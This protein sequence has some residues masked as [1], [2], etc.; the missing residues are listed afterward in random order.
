MHTY[1]L[2]TPTE[3]E[4][5]L[6]LMQEYYE[7]DQHDFDEGK[8][9]QALTPFLAEDRYGLAWLI[10]DAENVIGYVVIAFG[11]SLEFGGRDAFLDEL[12][13]R[14]AYRGQGIGTHTMQHIQEACKTHNIKALHL[15]VMDYNPKAKEFYQQLGFEARQSRLMSLDL[16]ESHD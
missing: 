12:Y 14:E 7:Y 10:Q 1:K 8:A 6:I 9:R 13:I 11:Y 16:R 4:T 5:L 3:L 15:E 2:C